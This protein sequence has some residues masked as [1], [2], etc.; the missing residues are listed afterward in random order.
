MSLLWFFMAAGTNLMNNKAPTE[1]LFNLDGS[2]N[3]NTPAS[4]ILKIP[5]IILNG[6]DT[7]NGAFYKFVHFF[8]DYYV[9][10]LQIMNIRKLYFLVT[11]SITMMACLYV[12]DKLNFLPIVY[13][14]LTRFIL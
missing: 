14:N 2:I 1:G 5:N 7:L 11:L 12:L 13:L 9:E 6:L 3:G 8:T 4:T 10:A